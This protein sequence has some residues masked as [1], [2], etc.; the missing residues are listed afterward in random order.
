MI[1]ARMRTTSA[2]RK[3]I[4]F[5][6]NYFNKYIGVEY[7]AYNTCRIRMLSILTFFEIL[8]IRIL[9]KKY[10]K[11]IKYFL[12]FKVFFKFEFLNFF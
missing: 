3:F 5:P 1:Q 9:Q 10:V 8:R 7:S 6:K 4:R 11:Y 12:K 2:L